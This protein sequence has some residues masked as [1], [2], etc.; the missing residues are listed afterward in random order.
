MLLHTKWYWP[1]YITTILLPY[2][3]KAAEDHCNKYD[4]DDDGVSPEEKNSNTQIVRNLMDAHTWGCPVY[5][6]NAC[7]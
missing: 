3:L 1:E 5:I 4:V 7:L 2:A 6:L